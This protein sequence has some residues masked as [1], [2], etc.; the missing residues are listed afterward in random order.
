MFIWRLVY[1]R[2]ASGKSKI[3]PIDAFTIM[4]KIRPDGTTDEGD[5]E[6]HGSA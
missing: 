5:L 3:T 4:L 6:R 1:G 2:S